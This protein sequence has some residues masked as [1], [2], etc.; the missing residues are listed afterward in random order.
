MDSRVGPNDLDKNKS[1]ALTGVRTPGPSN[2]YS[3]SVDQGL[4]FWPDD[5]VSLLRSSWI[6]SVLSEKSM[7]SISK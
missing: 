1:L 5:A 2:Q 4:K 3:H 6:F 7:D